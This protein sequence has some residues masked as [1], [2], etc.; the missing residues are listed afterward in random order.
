MGFDQKGL[1]EHVS[2]T[3]CRMGLDMF[4]SPELARDSRKTRPAQH[5]SRPLIGGCNA[6]VL[7]DASRDENEATDRRPLSCCCSS[8]GIP[9]GTYGGQRAASSPR[10][11]PPAFISAL[12]ASSAPASPARESRG[13]ARTSGKD[14]PQRRR[15][16]CKGPSRGNAPC[17]RGYTFGGWALSSFLNRAFSC[18]S[19]SIWRRQA[20]AADFSFSCDGDERAEYRRNV[21]QLANAQVAANASSVV[22]P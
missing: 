7:C 14:G 20:S 9:L 15:R 11:L 21:A 10:S 1:L 3:R 18:V 13:T 8:V 5:S 12:R 6:L 17:G 16:K 4:Q 22:M 2:D 19:L